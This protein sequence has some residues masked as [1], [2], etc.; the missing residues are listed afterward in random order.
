MFYEDTILNRR[1][2]IPGLTDDTTL[3]FQ[4][5]LDD[6]KEGI[7]YSLLFFILSS[8]SCM[9]LHRLGLGGEKLELHF[10]AFLPIIRPLAGPLLSTI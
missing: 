7:F 9:G 4:S 5:E 2:G 10:C 3:P 6:P 8:P 1:L